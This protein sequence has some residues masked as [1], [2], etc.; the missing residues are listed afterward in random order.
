LKKILLIG[1][2]G[3]IGHHLALRLKQFCFEIYIVDNLQVNNLL[4][5]SANKLYRRFITDRIDLIKQLDIALY[6]LD[7]R[8]YNAMSRVVTEVEPD[9]VIHLAA[10]AH[11]GKSNKDPNSTFDHSLR[12]LENVLDTARND[13]VGHF[14]Y[15]SSSMVYGDFIDHFVTEESPLEPIGIYGALKVAGELM[16][17]SHGAVFDIPYTIIRPSALYG[18]RCVSRRVVQIF[19]ENAIQGKPIIISGDGKEKLDFTFIDDLVQGIYLVVIADK[20]NI[21]NKTFNL[22]YGESRTINE[23]AD[24]VFSRFPVEVKYQERD[25]LVPYRG[26]L[27]VGLAESLL[28]YDPEF[29]IEKGI[30]KYIEWYLDMK[31]DKGLWK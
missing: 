9:V 16:V 23:I 15:F 29:P 24:M 22:T 31:K 8:D 11:A 7:A 25:K 26:T 4:A 28:G 5:H 30:N 2:L 18:P 12:T 13:R 20:K 21:R 19:I 6:I 17:K 3:F 10:V 1:G 27:D 14:I